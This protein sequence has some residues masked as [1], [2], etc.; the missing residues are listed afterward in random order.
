MESFKPFEVNGLNSRVVCVNDCVYKIYFRYAGGKSWMR[1][2][3]IQKRATEAVKYMLKNEFECGALKTEDLV[4]VPR[5]KGTWKLCKDG[6][7]MNGKTKL[8]SFPKKYEIWFKPLNEIETIPSLRIQSARKASSPALKNPK[9]RRKTTTPVGTKSTSNGKREEKKVLSVVASPSKLKRKANSTQQSGRFESPKKKSPKKVLQK[10]SSPRS[11]RRSVE[12]KSMSEMRKKAIAK[13][14]SAHKQIPSKADAN[15]DPRESSS[16]I[17]RRIGKSPIR[18]PTRGHGSTPLPPKNSPKSIPKKRPKTTNE[19]NSNDT[20]KTLSKDLLNKDT[21]RVKASETK[22]V[23]STPRKTRDKRM[24]TTARTT[25]G[26]TFRAR[27]LPTSPSKKKGFVKPISVERTRKSSRS[28]KKNLERDFSRKGDSESVEE[29]NGPPLR[30]LPLR[31]SGSKYSTAKGRSRV[32]PRSKPP[33]SLK[34][35]PRSSIRK[36]SYFGRGKSKK[37]KVVGEVSSEEENSWSHEEETIQEEVTSEE[38]DSDA[39]S[40]KIVRR[41]GRTR[42]QP[43][44]LGTGPSQKRQRTASPPGRPLRSNRR[45]TAKRSYAEETGGGQEI[46]ESSSESGENSETFIATK[47][48]PPESIDDA[49]ERIKRNSP[50]SRKLEIIAG[51]RQTRR[52]TDS[53]SESV[54]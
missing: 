43:Q 45:N 3:I 48:K 44:R 30:Q 51:L 17:N 37:V 41:S 8:K 2:H 47:S 36:S 53:N 16:K 39:S 23:Q 26:K 14:K 27:V 13:V 33:S 22:S 1:N 34:N 12:K 49:I 42:N 29:E 35:A 24:E 7:F 21:E 28:P 31:S 32:S 11:E 18:S 25:G 10:I 50:K 20:S 9:D 6:R 38:E 5:V 40:E 19:E 52:S 46:E 4:L 15:E 54:K